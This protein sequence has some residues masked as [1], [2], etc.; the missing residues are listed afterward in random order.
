MS[1]SS[2]TMRTSRDLLRKLVSACWSF[3]MRF[4]AAMGSLLLRCPAPN[5]NSSYSVSDISASCA[6]ALHGHCVPT[7]F[8]LPLALRSMKIL[9]IALR[10]DETAASRFGSTLV[11]ALVFSSPQKL[12]SASAFWNLNFA[13]GE[14]HFI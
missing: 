1:V 14:T 13:K 3:E 10:A 5:T 2:A 6:L 4:H 12:I 8:S 7:H 9:L 11:S